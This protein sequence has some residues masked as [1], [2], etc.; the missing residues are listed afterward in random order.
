V[1]VSII[2]TPTLITSTTQNVTLDASCKAAVFT[3]S[4]Y[5]G[6]GGTGLNAVT[7]GGVAPDYIIE[8][9]NGSGGTDSAATGHA[10]WLNP[11]TGTKSLVHSF[12]AATTE[13]PMR[14]LVQLTATGG[15][16]VRGTGTARGG[17]VSAIESNVP[18]F[19]LTGLTVGDLVVAMDQKF[20]AV[21]TNP[22]GW[23]SHQTQGPTNSEGAR[24]RSIAA[25]TT[26]QT[27]SGNG[28]DYSTITGAAFYE[29]ATTVTG[30][31]AITLDAMTVA[32]AGA[33][34]RKG[35]GAIT[36]PEMTVAGAGTRNIMG[37][38][39]ILLPELEVAGV[40]TVG[41]VVTG[42]GDIVLPELQVDG[43]GVRQA[44]G[45]GDILLPE[46]QV[47][48]AGVRQANGTG[49]I[50]LPE[51]EVAGAGAVER[52][53]TGDIVLP[54]LEVAGEGSTF[55]GIGGSG[56]I[57]FD[58]LEVDGAG[59]VQAV[60][61]GSGDITLPELLVEGAGARGA[62]GSG[63][64][65]LPE[66][67][68][69]GYDVPPFT[70]IFDYLGGTAVDRYGRMVTSFIEPDELLV[71]PHFIEGFAHDESGRRLV[72]T[73]PPD[74]DYLAGLAVRYDGVQVIAPDTAPDGAVCGIPVTYRGETCVSDNFPTQ[75]VEG[76]GK[77]AQGLLCVTDKG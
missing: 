52:K 20:N 42:S 50:P 46:L 15:I 38:G 49:D 3:W 59:T 11:G 17:S 76:F 53:G 45:T 33:V 9:T 77:D 18:S 1:A 36:L 60:S 4:Y 23:T 74:V 26:S 2:G 69:S 73:W 13:G 75:W 32:G 56:S 70:D 10:I 54:T 58:P 21:P 63:A 48:G 12:D 22:A 62:V 24:L 66:M 7:L 6:S 31:G 41:A 5:N 43:A 29:T 68:V 30:S 51:L 8:A 34:E 64:I 65:T 71:V 16:G 47:D 35:S 72:T 19:N 28:P 40:G 67:R 27:V 44:N 57:T 25:A 39:A 61:T 55:A 37:S 14:Q